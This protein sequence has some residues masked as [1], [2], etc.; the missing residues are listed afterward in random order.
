VKIRDQLSLLFILFYVLSL[1]ACASLPKQEIKQ[2]GPS[3]SKIPDQET[4]IKKETTSSNQIPKEAKIVTD[5]VIREPDLL[6]ISVWKE[7]DLKT[8]VAVRPDGKISFPL[9]GDVFVRGLTP[10]DLKNLMAKKLAK[11]IVDPLVFVKIEKIE[12]SR[13]S[14]LGAVRKPMIVPLT[15]QTSLLEAITIAGGL[16]ASG[17]TGK[18]AG[19]L[20]NAYIA[21]NNAILDI[22]IFKLLRENDMSQNIVLKSGDF[23][24]I[25]F[26][27]SSGSEVYVMGEVNVPG[28]KA[29]KSG[30]TLVEA[31]SKADGLKKGDASPYITIIRGGL[32]N[33]EVIRIDYREIVKG[34]TSQNIELKTRDIIY[35]SS[36]PLTKWNRVVLKILPTLE[37]LLMPNAY[38]NAYTTGGG[39]RIKTG[40][41]P[42]RPILP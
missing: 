8:K 35:V 18:E 36:T 16:W 11:Y 38:R 34:D 32:K 10:E 20:S 17:D 30:T 41:P 9:I 1:S 23:I 29:F 28:V 26:A 22:D 5:Y 15:H 31:L 24:Y 27:D 4:A 19:D 7:P 14:V 39:L 12:S 33:P 3:I 2:Q 25:P 21:R 13:V 40:L 6:E 37:L 42:Q